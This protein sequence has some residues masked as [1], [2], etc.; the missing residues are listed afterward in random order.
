MRAQIRSVLFVIIFLFSFPLASAVEV[1]YGWTFPSDA[2]S[3]TAV[4]TCSG[5]LCTLYNG[6]N[7]TTP[8]QVSTNRQVFL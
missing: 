3:W 1:S 5:S 4:G 8:K 6:W 2:Q 7:S